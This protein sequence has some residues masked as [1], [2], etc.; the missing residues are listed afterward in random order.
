MRH[1]H[2]A[3][4]ARGFVER[5]ARVQAQRLGHID[6]HVID[7]V[8]IPDRLEQAVGKS[9]RQNVLR[10]LLPQEMVDAEDLLLREHLVQLRVQRHRARE[11]RAEG[12]LHHDA[13]ALHELGLAQQAHRGQGS[14]GR[15]AQI[16][17]PPAL[18]LEGPLGS[19]HGGP[20]RLRSGRQR[21][22]V[23]TLREAV[24]VIVLRLARG[25]LVQRLLCTRA[26]TLGIE[27]VER[28]A[29]HPAAGDEADAGQVEESGQQLA[30][31]QV[32]GGS[33]EHDDMRILRAYA[34]W[35]L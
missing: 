1:D 9:K 15:H 24:P 18:S 5:R 12:L 4:G 6:L 10:R 2:V 7:E 31:R 27:V 20:E 35:N 11:I 21:D 19:L 14:I 30:P 29:D 22:V 3:K 32:A 16:V 26:E 23:Q 17:E 13:R 28:H 25:E 33:H 8:T 34:C